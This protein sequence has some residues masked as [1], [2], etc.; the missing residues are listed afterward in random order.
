MDENYLDRLLH[1]VEDDPTVNKTLDTVLDV[2]EQ[3]QKDVEKLNH[4]EDT[5]TQIKVD[6]IAEL[7]DL[8]DLADLDMNE[9][10]FDDIDF[11]DVDVTS[12]D[13]KLNTLD[14]ALDDFKE[15]EDIDDLHID[16]N[17]LDEDFDVLEATEEEQDNSELSNANLENEK[18]YN[19]DLVVD[20]FSNNS[21]KDS[22]SA[23]NT[24]LTDIDMLHSFE[25]EADINSFD[26]PSLTEQ[27]N[28]QEIDKVE[29]NVDNQPL[30]D[31][32]QLNDLFSLLGIDDENASN[33]SVNHDNAD[34]N[35]DA[36]NALNLLNE[37][38]EDD[39]LPELLDI[40]DI[41]EKKRKS[42]L[43]FLFGE[44]EETQLSEE[45]ETQLR[46]KQEEKEKE[47]QAKKE[48][49]KAKKQEKIEQN[50][51]SKEAK[52]AKLITKKQAKEEAE[53]KEFALNGPDKPLNKAAVT[54]IFLLFSIISI[55]L[56]ITTNRFNY[57]L[58]VKKATNYFERQKYKLAYYEILG[59]DVK[60]KDEVLKD[61]IY[62]VMYVE[63]QYE[64][65]ENQIKMN[66]PS[67]ALNALLR[68]LSKYDDY[69]NEAVTLGVEKDLDI[70]KAKI[71][72]ALTNNFGLSEEQ[73]KQ[74][75]LLDNDEYTKQIENITNSN[76]TDT[77]E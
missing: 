3:I 48:N 5:D 74:I 77:K 25:T 64:A 39:I 21:D 10:D 2:E 54:I 16:S 36:D 62:T 40:P 13:T 33:D 75:N 11:D 29:N 49:K 65:Y 30:N 70:S 69:Y 20:A 43:E 35:T 17:Y 58:S 32:T 38:T 23:E 63:R 41:H 56:I 4:V 8:D 24:V 15:N 68:G 34:Q 27:T 22:I 52:Q 60:E 71:I 55:S 37:S 46:V 61:R 72:D 59:I 14:N 31:E 51:F 53:A 7:D 67:K 50:K 45:E 1:E 76:Q 6:E 19:E 57:T 73:A 47:K 44:E 9:L 66:N 42:F 26:T 12:F 18:S 28:P